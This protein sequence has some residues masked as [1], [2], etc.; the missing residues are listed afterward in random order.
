MTGPDQGLVG[1][2]DM[3]SEHR[4]ST[5]VLYWERTEQGAGCAPSQ[6]KLLT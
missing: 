3:V 6:Y 4:N 1:L 2:N 5:V